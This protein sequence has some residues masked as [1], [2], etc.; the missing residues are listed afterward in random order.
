M[1]D[2]QLYIDGELADIDENTK[3]TLNYKSN[4]FRDVTKIV[5]NNSYTVK[6]PKTVRNMKIFKHVKLD[7]R[8]PYKEHSV[9]YLR[10]GVEVIKNGRLF[11]LNVTN[12]AFEVSVV[13][14]VTGAFLELSKADATLN[15]LRSDAVILY[16]EAPAATAWTT[17]Q[18]LKETPNYAALY[19]GYS[20]VR[21]MTDEERDTWSAN[22]GSG[23][24]YDSVS[25]GGLGLLDFT[26]LYT[27]DVMGPLN[28][29]NVN[30]TNPVIRIGWLL[31]L[32]RQQYGVSFVF[33][34]LSQAMVDD[35]AII[36]A[37]R[38]ANELTV[39][40]DFEGTFNS[41]QGAGTLSFTQTG[42]NATMV[43]VENGN[44]LR[45]NGDGKLVMRV[46]GVNTRV[47][48]NG[49]PGILG[50]TYYGSSSWI[51]VRVYDA[52]NN[53]RTSFQCGDW[54]D[55]TN[56]LYYINEGGIT[57]EC[58]AGVGVIDVHQGESIVFDMTCYPENYQFN[59][60]GGSI[61]AKVQ[62]S[63]DVQYGQY[64]PLIYNLPNIKVMDLIKFLSIVTGTFPRQREG[65]VVY[66]DILDTLWDN[67]DRAYN[68]TSKLI[69]Q[70]SQNAPKNLEYNFNDYAQ[71]NLM[72]WKKDETV[73]GN[74]DGDLQV[75]NEKLNYEKVLAELPFAAS[76][77]IVPLWVYK[78]SLSYY[79]VDNQQWV[80]SNP[81]YEY[82]KIEA[83]VV[84]LKESSDHTVIAC[85]DLNMQKVIDTKYARLQKSLEN[86]KVIKENF[87]LSVLDIMDIDETIPVYLAQYGRY[88]AICEIK[89]NN[90]D[91]AEVTM[92]ELAM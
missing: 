28:G 38:K 24:T 69:P 48:T 42:G 8:F 32:I 81:V 58:M 22:N 57:Y 71:H 60:L 75:K 31:Q 50:K 11:V 89:L 80:L 12:K 1:K 61:S 54:G 70:G 40:G 7:E 74:Y 79:D 3:I 82:Q 84:R 72:K 76:D 56:F 14:G 43:S 91:V 63:G 2:E 62:S 83:R 53:Q 9:K 33:D 18:N 6:L 92:L 73:V 86:A 78:Y 10:S 68:W 20:S 21:S 4:L 45:V 52:N 55:K 23:S 85:F 19:A 35:L 41:G 51:T 77:S 66:F 25:G 64:Y 90:N 5:S 44:R 37:E 67:R 17:Y 59:F 34:S 65:D 88:Y 29:G 30:R 49:T 26:S 87:V 16:Q 27:A 47:Y 15:D 13:W 39:G 46:V 36:P